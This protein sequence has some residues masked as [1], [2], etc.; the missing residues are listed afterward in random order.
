VA[1]LIPMLAL[2]VVVL[3]GIK[4]NPLKGPFISD[5]R[6]NFSAFLYKSIGFSFSFKYV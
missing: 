2:V 6:V 1:S 4:R 3:V 5:P